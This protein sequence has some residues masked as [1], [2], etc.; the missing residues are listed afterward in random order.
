MIF[1]R[2]SI[3]IYPNQTHQTMRTLILPVF[4]I[5]LYSCDTMVFFT[6]PQPA[7]NRDLAEFP[8]RFTGTYMERDEGSLYRITA[9]SILELQ[10]EDLADPIEEILED[11]DVEL[12]GDSLVIKDM[13]LVFPVKRKNDSVFGTVVHFDTVF[14]THRGCRLRKMGKH[15][16]LNLP[17]DTLWIVAKLNFGRDETVYRCEIDHEKEM[18]IFEK[19]CK[20]EIKEDD[21]GWQSCILSP[22][23]KE[24]RKLLRMGTFTDSIPYIRVDQ[25]LPR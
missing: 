19:H 5:L 25:E 11:G 14:D 7:G 3:F 6:E 18:E 4:I 12:R 20:V 16:F 10:Q 1:L 9:S 8:A 17:S 22:S 23:K 13:N 2:Y 15:Y 24:L 21:D